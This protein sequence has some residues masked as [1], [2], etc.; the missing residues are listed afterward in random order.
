MLEARKEELLVDRPELPDI[1][2]VPSSWT[3]YEQ[4]RSRLIDWHEG[5]WEQ[6]R[7]EVHSASEE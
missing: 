2:A 1:D 4:N 5:A 7:Q 3:E 6:L